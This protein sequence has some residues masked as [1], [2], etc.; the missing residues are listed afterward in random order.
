[1]PQKCPGDSLGSSPRTSGMSRPDLC[2]I[3]DRLDGMSA[4]QQDISTG[5]MGNVHV[6]LAVQ[7]WGC[8]AE[9][10]CVYRF[11]LRAETKG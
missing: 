7:K 1:M 3:P 9:F 4:G 6:M 5:Q 11:F 10:L 2:V 8:P